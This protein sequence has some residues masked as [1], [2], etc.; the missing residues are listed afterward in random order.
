V[1][2]SVGATS[3]VTV[4]DARLKTNI[5]K[6]DQPLDKI[7]QLQGYTYSF[8]KGEKTERVFP[9]GQKIGLLAQE[10][11]KVFPEAVYKDNEGYLGVDYNS[12]IP[13][14][15]EAIKTLKTQM[16]FTK[17]LVQA[18]I[19]STRQEMAVLEEQGFSLKQNYP[20]PAS[21]GTSIVYKMPSGTTGV[22]AI[23]SLDG[24][25][26]K[27]ITDIAPGGGVATLSAADIKPGLYLYSLI[28]DGEIVATKK[29][30]VE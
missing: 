29:M 2:G 7:A 19:L 13:P 10:V 23:H 25:P 8:K 27:T 3:Y 26:V 28:V 9:E 22:I 17:E 16:D 20:N 30:V 4:S 6:L 1:N 11:E 5:Q 18:K 21:Q 24:K 15:L 12:L 14:M